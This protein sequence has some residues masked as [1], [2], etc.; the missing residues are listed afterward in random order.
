MKQDSLPPSY[1][2][3]L[4]KHGGK[5]AAILQGVKE[6]ATNTQV[7]NLDVIEKHYKSMGFD[8]KLDPNM[9]LPC[10]VRT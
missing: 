2:A 6:L 4:N 9:K 3:F 5:A 10:S 1:K 8:L 7:T